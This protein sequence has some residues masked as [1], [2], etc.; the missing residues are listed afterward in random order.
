MFKS[1]FARFFG[2]AEHTA[3]E[4]SVKRNAVIPSDNPICSRENDLFE[5]TSIAE[6]FAQHI[7]SLNAEEGAV[8]SVVGP[9]GSGKTSFINLVKEKLNASQDNIF[10]LDFN[11]WL[12]SG[13]D[14]LVEKFFS[15]LSTTM[16]YDQNTSL[17]KTGI[18]ISQYSNRLHN[19][20]TIASIFSIPYIDRIIKA[21]AD[22]MKLSKQPNSIDK[23]REKITGQ[24]EDYKKPVVVIIDDIDRL[25]PSEI[26]DIFK[27]VRLTANFPNLR[28]ILAFDR[29]R[30]EQVFREMNYE[31]SDYI[32]KIVQFQYRL[33]KL[34]EH[35]F[36]GQI[37]TEVQKILYSFDPK[38]SFDDPH[39]NNVYHG[40]VEPLF[41]NMRDVR[42]YT[43]AV[44]CTLTT[45]GNR[46]ETID[47]LVLDAIRI[48]L[49]KIFEFLPTAIET[50][51][52]TPN[53]QSGRRLLEEVK[54]AADNTHTVQKKQINKLLEI[55]RQS[56]VEIVKSMIQHLFPF[57]RRYLPNA[58][59]EDLDS[60][61]DKA[62]T[63]KAL[64]DNRVAHED[65]FRLYLECVANPGLVVHYDAKKA[66]KLMHDRQQLRRFLKP[67]K[68]EEAL[69]TI[70]G[71]MAFE[72]EFRAKHVMPSIV[73]CFNLLPEG[74][75]NHDYSSIPFHDLF[76]PIRSVASALFAVHE[77]NTPAIDGAVT[78]IWPK[79]ETLSAKLM[80]I[81][82]V[83][84]KDKPASRK[85]SAKK[86][87][88][89]KKLMLDDIE[90]AQPQELAI[91]INIYQIARYARTQ[92]QS[93]SQ[94][95]D[96]P[97][98]PELTFAV[99][100]DS[101]IQ[102]MPEQLTIWKFIIGI[103]GDE[104]KLKNRISHLL[105]NRKSLDVWLKPTRIPSSDVDELLD[106]ASDYSKDE[107]HPE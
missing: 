89:L 3:T 91:E 57:A 44:Q 74:P 97:D 83:D 86:A 65:V 102:T 51:T 41:R 29:V 103:F 37:R 16:I 7:L 101:H 15:E 46:V 35:L 9:W 99:L 81:Y 17:R 23:L 73:T 62:L 68:L 104:S 85:I 93:R 22:T 90:R 20:L 67:M 92:S 61:H 71:L 12:F 34:P 10:V 2:K 96:F 30:I 24:L 69:H 84:P 40:I 53:G 31:G 98:S 45:L 33:P 63:D 75:K 80:L 105:G 94:S 72:D 18:A 26:L 58:S 95:W 59:H 42:R 25:S 11:P 1:F 88:E 8:A 100:W 107:F 79:L 66:F 70:S 21:S 32:D 27:M 77:A 38:R 50:L 4:S 6:T 39:W 43:A 55:E 106:L 5:R 87:D 13:S 48:F 76:D 47:V 60:T 82:L 78:N 54:H 56:R 14:K 49:P 52:A 64:K 36:K 19:A 28:Y